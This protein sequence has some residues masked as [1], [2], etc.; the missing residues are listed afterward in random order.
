MK[1]Y[2]IVFKLNEYEQAPNHSYYLGTFDHYPTLNEFTNA[3]KTKCLKYLDSMSDR[4]LELF[5]NGDEPVIKY[6]MPRIITS[7]LN[8]VDDYE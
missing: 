8:K 4:D 5:Y 7:T 3:C 1:L 6:A 2:H